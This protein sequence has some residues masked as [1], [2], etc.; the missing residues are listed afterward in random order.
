MANKEIINIFNSKIDEV[1]IKQKVIAERIGVSEDRLSR[2]LSCRSN[3][4]AEELLTLCIVL[5]VD[6]NSLR[7][8]VA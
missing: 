7:D 4:L 6:P 1:G 2:I 3:M 5:N 8:I